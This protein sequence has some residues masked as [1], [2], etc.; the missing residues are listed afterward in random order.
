MGGISRLSELA[1]DEAGHVYAVDGEGI[2]QW[3][4]MNGSTLERVSHIKLTVVDDSND[5]T[6]ITTR[7]NR[8]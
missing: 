7:P 2:G 1:A 8:T 6:G 4:L 5:E 3:R